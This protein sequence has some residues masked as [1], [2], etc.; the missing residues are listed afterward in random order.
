MT[1]AQWD[2]FGELMTLRQAMDRLFEEAW[3]RPGR[4]LAAEGF[5]VPMDVAE[6][7]HYITV[8]VALPGVRPEEVDVSVVG[9]VLTIRGEHKEEQEQKQQTWHRRELRYGRFERS[10]T[11]PTE[12]Q[13]DQA[14]TNFEYGILTLRLPKAEAAR[15]KR[16]QIKS[17][18]PPIEGSTR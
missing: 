12:V 16:I 4:F 18:Q 5:S 15:P 11:L 9:N 8:K 10:L 13:A 6:D 17:Q 1:L 7:E 2:P 14:E 3:V